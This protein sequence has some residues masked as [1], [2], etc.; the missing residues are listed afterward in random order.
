MN[1]LINNY[2]LELKDKDGNPTGHFY[3]DQD[4][5]KGVCMEVLLN[6]AHYKQDKANNWIDSNFAGTWTHFDVNNDNI[7]EV[8]RMPQFLRYFVHDALDLDLQ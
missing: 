7:V 3:L 1:S 6:N 8:E 5:A 2:A 4:A